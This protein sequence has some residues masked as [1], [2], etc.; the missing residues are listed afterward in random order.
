MKPTARLART[1]DLTGLLRLFASSEVSPAAEPRSRAE[2]IWS[3][4]LGRAGVSVFVSQSG[5]AIAATCMLIVAPNLLRGGR[6]HGF[7]EN[8]ITHP[9]F[10]GQGYGTC[11]LAAAL[12]QAWRE[13]CHHVL[14][15][16]GRDDPRVLNFYR[17]AGFVPGLRTAYVAARPG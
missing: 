5:E 10:R 15:Q 16:S 8:V 7:I 3:E 6:Q 1:S 12:E 14:L 2:G 11:V 4:T 13:D 9:D 17:K